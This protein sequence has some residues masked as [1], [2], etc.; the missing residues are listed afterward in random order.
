TDVPFE[1]AGGDPA[2]ALLP[3]SEQFMTNYVFLAPEKYIEDYV[4]ITHPAGLTV[5]L[6]DNPVSAN[7]DCDTE[8]FSADWDITR[9]LIPDFTHTIDAEEP[10]G[11]TVWGY[12]GRVSYGYTGGLDL[13]EINPVVVE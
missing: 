9:C 10:V 1:G 7:P 3:P 5:N 8:V 13:T 4:V 6:D 12:G 2:F 11:I